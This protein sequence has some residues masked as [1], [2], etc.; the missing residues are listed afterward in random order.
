MSGRRKIPRT[1]EDRHDSLFQKQHFEVGG[2]LRCSARASEVTRVVCS[3]TCQILQVFLL[4]QQWG[5]M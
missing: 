3:L 4:S 2:P 5:N 1:N